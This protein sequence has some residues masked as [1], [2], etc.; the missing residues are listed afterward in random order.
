MKLWDYKIPPGWKPQTDEEWVW[1]L[2][3]RL[4]YGDVK[5]LDPRQIHKYLPM[6]HLDAGKRLLWENY[7]KR[8]AVK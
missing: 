1:Y 4:N 2:R 3:R 7:F 6:L 8:Y 5:G